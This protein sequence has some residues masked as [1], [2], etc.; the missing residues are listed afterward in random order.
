MSSW[1]RTSSTKLVSARPRPARLRT[2]SHRK[3][4]SP[5]RPGGSPS[6]AAHRRRSSSSD[7][8]RAR[9]RAASRA[10]VVPGSLELQQLGSSTGDDRPGLGLL[11]L[12]AG[13]S[14]TTRPRTAVAIRLSTDSLS[15]CGQAL[16]K[17]S[18]TSARVDGAEAHPVDEGGPQ[19]RAGLRVGHLRQATRHGRQRAGVEGHGGPGQVGGV[20]HDEPARGAAVRAGTTVRVAD[21][22]GRHP[23][24]L[25][26]PGEPGDVEGVRPVGGERLRDLP[27]HD[28]RRLV[29]RDDVEAGGQQP[30]LAP[31]RRGPGPR[32]A[33]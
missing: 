17:V 3:S 15:S 29:G 27:G 7:E 24:H 23:E 13:R 33:P 19:H 4:E 28:T 2:T 12:A 5:S 18:T 30:G 22:R 26:G 31:R 25:L 16:P 9:D 8:L 10:R 14:V 21:Q 32:R 6:P 11:R 20:G 1:E